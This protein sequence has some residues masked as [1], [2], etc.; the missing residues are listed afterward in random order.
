MVFIYKIG[1]VCALI[2]PK[3]SFWFLNPKNEE[4]HDEI[5]WIGGILDMK[6]CNLPLALHTVWDTRVGNVKIH[7]EMG[8]SMNRGVFMQLKVLNP[9]KKKKSSGMYL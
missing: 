4:E 9:K 5:K 3:A 2:C 1:G 6:R 7:T 8:S